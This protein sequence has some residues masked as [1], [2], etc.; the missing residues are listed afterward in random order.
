MQKRLR[1]APEKRFIQQWIM[2]EN[3]EDLAMIMQDYAM[4]IGWR[5]IMVWYWPVMLL[6]L[7][8]MIIGW[9]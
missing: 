1:I 5:M 7:R 4:I 8:V 2:I 3:K 6:Q 9:R